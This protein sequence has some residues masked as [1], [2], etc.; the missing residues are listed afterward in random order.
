[1][2]LREYP[3]AIANL[4]IEIHRINL[5]V[6]ILQN[7]LRLIEYDIDQQIAFDTSLTNDAKRKSMRVAL[8]EM[9]PEYVGYEIKLQGLKSQHQ[10]AWIDL[11]K[12]RGEFSVSKL[13][14][15]ERIARLEISL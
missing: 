13:E 12:L 8:L 4:E 6:S 5:E 9:H 3:N 10:Y 1:M 11:E 7:N 15:R 2:K 14:T